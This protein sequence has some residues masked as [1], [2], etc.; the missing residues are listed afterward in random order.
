VPRGRHRGAVPVPVPGL[1]PRPAPAVRAAD[2]LPY[3][4]PKRWEAA[5]PRGIGEAG[6]RRRRAVGAFGHSGPTIL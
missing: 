4:G 1:R 5:G 6:G 3:R 2:R